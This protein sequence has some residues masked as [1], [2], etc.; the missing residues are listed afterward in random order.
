MGGGDPVLLTG[1][2]TPTTALLE[3][4]VPVFLQGDL[5]DGVVLSISLFGHTL[6]VAVCNPTQSLKSSAERG[7]RGGGG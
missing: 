2:A 7:E 3:L 1:V 4:L 5:Y 6:E